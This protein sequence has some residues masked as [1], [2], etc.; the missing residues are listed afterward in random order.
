[1]SAICGIVQRDGSPVAPE[2]IETLMQALTVYGP[3]GRG[4]WREGCAALGQ[5][6]LHTTPESVSETLPWQDPES[7]LVITTDAWLDNCAELSTAIRSSSAVEIVEMPDTPPLPRP[8]PDT[9]PD[10]N[11]ALVKQTLQRKPSRVFRGR[12]RQR[13]QA[14][15]FA[16]HVI[17]TTDAPENNTT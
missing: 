1:M 11:I 17:R 16:L 14:A 10:L 4:V 2:H 9:H 8:L 13:R 5:Q 7:G 6:M 15:L 12:W 3:D